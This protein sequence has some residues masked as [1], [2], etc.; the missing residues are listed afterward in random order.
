MRSTVSKVRVCFWGKSSVE[1]RRTL[2]QG[3]KTE[4]SMDMLH[5]KTKIRSSFLKASGTGVGSRFQRKRENTT[6]IKQK[7]PAPEPCR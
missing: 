7:M 1:C 6:W 4:D 5:T 2:Q 3:K